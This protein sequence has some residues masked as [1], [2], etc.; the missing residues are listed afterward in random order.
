[1][2]NG[3]KIQVGVTV[4]EKELESF[5]ALTKVDANGPAVLAMARIGAEAKREGLGIGEVRAK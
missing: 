4:D 2:S 1:M 5:K 3:K